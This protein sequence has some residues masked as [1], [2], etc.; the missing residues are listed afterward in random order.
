MNV[1]INDD[2]KTHDDSGGAFGA[3]KIDELDSKQDSAAFRCAVQ[4]SASTSPRYTSAP[5]GIAESATFVRTVLEK[6]PSPYKEPLQAKE[7]S[8][9]GAE[10]LADFDEKILAAQK[11][12]LVRD[13]PEKNCSFLVPANLELLVI[14]NIICKTLRKAPCDFDVV[15]SK[16]KWKGVYHGFSAFVSFSIRVYF[17]HMKGCGTKRY[18]IVTRRLSGDCIA[19]RQLYGSLKSSICGGVCPAVNQFSFRNE[20]AAQWYDSSLS[21][22][23]SVERDV[24]ALCEMVE[25]SFLD[26]QIFALQALSQLIQ[27]NE[28]AKLCV[29]RNS[30]L[31]KCLLN[32]FEFCDDR[33]CQA[34]EDCHLISELQHH[35][36]TVLRGLSEEPSCISLLIQSGFLTKCFE[37]LCFVAKYEEECNANK[38][39]ECADGSPCINRHNVKFWYR[40]SQ[41]ET[42]RCFANMTD[43]TVDT[44]KV[45]LGRGIDDSQLAQW[46]ELTNHFSDEVVRQ[47]AKKF[48]PSI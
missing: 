16:C 9:G 14:A 40:Q 21:K 37:S 42:A 13:S 34:G 33:Y 45:L 12:D 47:S 48:I 4:P 30:K 5:V 35:T 15:E 3:F 29:V 10:G 8:A 25:S 1:R 18:I 22:A 20:P 28:A 27:S 17:A 2:K 6:Y 32:I 7:F 24:F 44:V 43:C 38:C 39:Q 36:T 26:Q 41:R 31:M 11:I 23:G 46:C 19:F